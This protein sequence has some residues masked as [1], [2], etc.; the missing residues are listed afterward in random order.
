MPELT[1]TL[2][3][4]TA[5]T[6]LI[7]GLSVSYLMAENFDEFMDGSTWAAFVALLWPVVVPMALILGAAIA[8]VTVIEG[9]L[10]LFWKATGRS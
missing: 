5:V 9:I 2:Y 8:I 6:F 4:I 3:L 10:K 1:N 7:I